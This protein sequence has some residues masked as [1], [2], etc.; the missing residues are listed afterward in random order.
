MLFR[1]CKTGPS[2]YGGDNPRFQKLSPHESMFLETGLT[3][4]EPQEAVFWLSFHRPLL[5]ME[6]FQ[7]CHNQLLQLKAG[8]AVTG[9]LPYPFQ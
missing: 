2:H 8:P 9:G 6:T 4:P 7:V 5:R 1:T 3:K